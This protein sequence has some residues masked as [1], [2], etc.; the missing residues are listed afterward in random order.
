MILSK[1]FY[2]KIS[3]FNIQNTTFNC[4]CWLLSHLSEQVNLEK[5]TNK[6]LTIRQLYKEENERTLIYQD[7]IK[8]FYRNT[9]IQTNC[10]TAR[11]EKIYAQT[12]Q[13]NRHNSRCTIAQTD[14]H[15]T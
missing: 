1:L 4:Q 8:H 2:F 11:H 7:P 13:I 14:R 10:Q 6:K 15:K 5:P 3:I 9:K 12:K